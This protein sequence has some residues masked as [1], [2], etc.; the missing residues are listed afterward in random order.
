MEIAVDLVRG[1][2][3]HFTEHEANILEFKV[4]R[5]ACEQAASTEKAVSLEHELSRPRLRGPISR[6]RMLACGKGRR[7][8]GRIVTVCHFTIRSDFEIRAYLAE[9]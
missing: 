9:T 8:R 5:F 6:D 7:I 3:C 1:E 4:V 2:G